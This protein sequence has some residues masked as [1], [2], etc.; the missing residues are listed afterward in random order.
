MLLLFL[1]YMF[2]YHPD[3]TT[4]EINGTADLVKLGYDGRPYIQ[5][6]SSW[7]IPS[8]NVATIA[9]DWF[10]DFDKVSDWLKIGHSKRY[11]RKI[12]T[13]VY[14]SDSTTWAGQYVH[15]LRQIKLNV[16]RLSLDNVINVCVHEMAHCWFH[17]NREDKALVKFVAFVLNNMHS[18]DYYSRGR[19]LQGFKKS[20]TPIRFVNEIHS[21]LAT[22]KHGTKTGENSIESLEQDE[23]RTEDE[24]KYLKMYAKEFDKVHPEK[25]RNKLWI[26][27][28]K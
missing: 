9:H 1:L 6:N 13:F 24:I 26:N 28:L 18:I 10:E 27:Y 22:L 12:S 7:I 14:C 16:A 19:K 23:N 2:K 21:I 3:E 15:R 8:K 11:V 4:I 25:P 17:N 5:D 20:K